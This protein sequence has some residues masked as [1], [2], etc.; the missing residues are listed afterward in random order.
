MTTV[1]QLT[2]TVRTTAG[3]TMLANNTSAA[4]VSVSASCS[5]ALEFVSNT[6]SVSP[7]QHCNGAEHTKPW[8]PG[9]EHR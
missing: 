6:S 4:T 5:A 1:R 9:S 2:T 3:S 7:H 8:P